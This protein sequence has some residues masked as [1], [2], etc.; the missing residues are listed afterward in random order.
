[1]NITLSKSLFFP[2]RVSK[3]S[4]LFLAHTPASLICSICFI[5]YH[6]TNLEK[7]TA[8]SM[9]RSTIFL[10]FPMSPNPI[11]HVKSHGREASSDCNCFHQN[12]QAYRVSGAKPDTVTAGFSS[13]GSFWFIRHL[14]ASSRGAHDMLYTTTAEHE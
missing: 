3:V 12:K 4:E 10:R 5:L 9:S 13:R 1:M 14:I 7:T 11:H 2:P 6:K 8:F